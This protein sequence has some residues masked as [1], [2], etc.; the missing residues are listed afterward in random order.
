MTDQSEPEQSGEQPTPPPPANGAPPPPSQPASPVEL[1]PGQTAH[2]YPPAQPTAYGYPQYYSGK[3][4]PAGILGILLGAWGVHRFYLSDI[5]GGVLRIL[6]TLFTC[7]IGGIIGFIEGIIYLTKT[8]PEF[9]Q[10]YVVQ[11]REW[12]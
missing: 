2:G 11:R 3:R 12:F 4:I 6:I 9:D 5:G 10:I 1:P 7:G 8:D